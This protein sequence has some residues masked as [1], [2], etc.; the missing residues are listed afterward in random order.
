M[1]H[2]WYCTTVNLHKINWKTSK[3]TINW[4]LMKTFFFRLKPVDIAFTATVHELQTVTEFMIIVP[5]SDK[6]SARTSIS[7]LTAHICQTTTST[8]SK[9]FYCPFTCLLNYNFISKIL[10]EYDC[11][12]LYI[13][14]VE[15][16]CKL[17]INWQWRFL[18]NKLTFIKR[19]T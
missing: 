16:L 11:T 9:L 18:S 5:S 15:F 3:I 7:P 2:S 8:F 13:E 4:T 19:T 1:S 17:H 14:Y 6:V 12:V 10:K